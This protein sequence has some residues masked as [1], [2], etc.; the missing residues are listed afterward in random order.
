MNCF[1]TLDYN[2]LHRASSNASSAVASTGPGKQ[3]PQGAFR[4]LVGSGM[5]G[6]G[7]PPPAGGAG[8]AG[9]IPFMDTSRETGSVVSGQAPQ[10]V[11]TSSSSLI[12]PTAALGGPGRTY[13]QQDLMAA[14]R[15][16][17]GS[18]GHATGV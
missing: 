4:P 13:Q 7:P 3:A 10:S 18:G 1:V 5:P 16:S 17:S 8:A 15:T 14:P 2:M 9:S 6:Q 11:R 12:R